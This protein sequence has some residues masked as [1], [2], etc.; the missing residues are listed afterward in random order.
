MMRRFTTLAAALFVVGL[1]QI[2][3]LAQAQAP[4]R[5]PDVIYVPTPQTVVDAMLKMANVTKNDVVYD[6][7]CGDGRIVITAAK[8]FGAR[9][10]GIDIDPQ[11]IKESNENAA[12]AGVTDKVKF[13]NSDIFAESTNLSEATV[14][15]LYLLPS[16]NVKLIPKLKRELK[17]GTRIVSNSFDMGEWEPEKTMEVDGRMIYFWTIPK[18]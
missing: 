17:P 5:T 6:L 11:R 8:Q 15:T 2:T 9:G 14:V 3:P 16:L 10:V 18:S 13:S 12:T 7:G 4:L 1:T